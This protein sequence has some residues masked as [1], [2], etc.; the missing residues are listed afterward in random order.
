[1]S[2]KRE[3]RLLAVTSIEIGDIAADGGVAPTF[4]SVGVIYKDTANFEQL[5][6]EDIEHECEE[7][8]DPIEVIAGAKK[9]IISWGVTDFDPANLVKLLGGTVTGEGENAVWNAP[10]NSSL[11]EKSVRI[12]PKRGKVITIARM[13]LTSRISYSLSKGGIGQVLISGK[14]LSPTLANTPPF[15]IG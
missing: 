4:E 10:S 5:E 14:M 8:D 13:S 15:T 12:T 6:P 9:T 3:K 11:I 1:M 2:E 7:L